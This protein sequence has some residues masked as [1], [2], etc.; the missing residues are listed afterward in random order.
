M[1]KNWVKDDFPKSLE[2]AITK[3]EISKSA[4]TYSVANDNLKSFITDTFGAVEGITVAYGTYENNLAYAQYLN[5]NSAA[6][7]ITNTI[8]MI[9]DAQ[10]AS[11]YLAFRDFGESLGFL[12]KQAYAQADTGIGFSGLRPLLPIWKA[13]RNL[14]YLF[15]S[16]IMIAIGFMIMFRKKID[17]QTVVTVQNAIPNIVIALL[18]ITFSYAIVGVLIDIMYIIMFVGLKLIAGAANSDGRNIFGPEV[19][20]MYMGSGMGQLFR[21]MSEGAF[22]SFDDITRIIL[23]GSTRRAILQGIFGAITFAIFP[24]TGGSLAWQPALLAALLG[25][26]VLFGFMRVF[27]MLLS[28]YIQ[29]IMS[30]IIGPFQLLFSAI[31]GNTA[32]SSWIKNLVA[33]LSVFPITAIMILIGTY[34]AQYDTVIMGGENLIDT[35]KGSIEGTRIWTP[36]LLSSAGSTTKGITGLI[37]LGVLMTIPTVAGSIKEALKAKPPVNVGIGS[38][39]APVGQTFQA[40]STGLSSFYYGRSFMQMLPFFKK[41]DQ[42][43]GH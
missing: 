7:G 18:L 20:D 36:P 22:S 10:P 27:F 21:G 37:A 11:T 26:A 3:D 35:V 33:H 42:Q 12:P 23:F 43:S 5:N 16:L 31:P 40:T 2:K 39:F 28:S 9:Y 6:R 34:L 14:A 30:L 32:F 13:F 25:I 41:G 15:L 8:A 24:V 19:V 1:E 29:I 4:Y 17:A 38:A